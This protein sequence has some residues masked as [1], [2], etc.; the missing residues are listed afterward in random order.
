MI[1]NYF[2]KIGL[3]LF[4]QLVIEMNPDAMETQIDNL[5]LN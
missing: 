1:M 3:I 4:H 2:E 5:L